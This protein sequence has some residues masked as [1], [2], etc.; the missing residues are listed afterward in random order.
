MFLAATAAV[1][2]AV[3][4][5]SLEKMQTQLWWQEWLQAQDFHTDYTL[6]AA[7]HT[8]LQAWS[9]RVGLTHFQSR[10]QR[11]FMMPTTTWYKALKHEFKHCSVFSDVLLLLSVLKY[12]V[13]QSTKKGALWIWDVSWKK[14]YRMTLTYH[15]RMNIYAVKKFEASNG[16]KNRQI[17]L[18]I[19][20]INMLRQPISDM[21]FKVT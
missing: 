7:K 21:I 5:V 13:D 18:D 9:C 15:N 1:K 14:S 12:W 3:S 19:L 20:Y 10:I 4:A 6:L 11:N 16:V 17:C 2:A 8:P